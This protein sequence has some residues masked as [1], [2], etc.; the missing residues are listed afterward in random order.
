MYPSAVA[1]DGTR[2]CLFYTASGT[3]IPVKDGADL[4]GPGYF[5]GR[6]PAYRQLIGLAEIDVSA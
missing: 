3:T 1:G 2:T 4:S 6:A 5:K